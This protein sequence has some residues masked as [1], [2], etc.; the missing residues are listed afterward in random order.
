MW[1]NQIFYLNIIPI[2]HQIIDT[3]FEIVWAEKI[4]DK[5]KKKESLPPHNQV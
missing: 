2:L 1:I 5:N 3:S 4:S